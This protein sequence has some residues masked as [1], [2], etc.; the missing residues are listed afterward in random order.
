MSAFQKLMEFARRK[1][2]PEN[3][4]RGEMKYKEDYLLDH[5]V[6]QLIMNLHDWAFLGCER[7]VVVGN[8]FDAVAIAETFSGKLRYIAIELKENDVAKVLRQAMIR[9]VAVHVTYAV[10]SSLE[11][12]SYTLPYI[13]KAVRSGIGIILYEPDTM[14]KPKLIAGARVNKHPVML[15]F[16]EKALGSSNHST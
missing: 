16:L 12:S 7:H 3:P 11:I 13:E 15:R 4:C 2:V 5:K 8:E 6:L 1:V 14:T 9:S 10:L